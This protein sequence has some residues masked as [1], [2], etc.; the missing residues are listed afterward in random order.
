MTQCPNCKR[1][2]FTEAY[3]KHKKNCVLINGEK[4]GGSEIRNQSERGY[5]VASENYKKP[6]TLTC[7]VCGREFGL[8]SLKIHYPKCI[9]KFKNAQKLKPKHERKPV[10]TFSEDQLEVIN[11]KEDW[12][13]EEIEDFNKHA[14]N[15][16]RDNAMTQC[17][18]CK[19]KFFTEAY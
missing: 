1:K 8:T 6:R 5:S 11:S 7:C 16:Y 15:N 14:N 19:R 9:E 18:N 2:F 12:T 3:A 13:E 17:P 10:P 4:G